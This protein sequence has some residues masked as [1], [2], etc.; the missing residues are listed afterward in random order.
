[1]QACVDIET[2]SVPPEGATAGQAR[3]AAG[4]EPD[5]DWQPL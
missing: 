1:M 5:P 4:T 3:A 2:F